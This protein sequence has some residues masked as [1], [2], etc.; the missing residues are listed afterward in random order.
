MKNVLPLSI[1]ER[2][3][4]LSNFGIST[5]ADYTGI[6]LFNFKPGSYHSKSKRKNNINHKM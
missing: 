1:K 2:Q 4:D 5:P 3:F 6:D